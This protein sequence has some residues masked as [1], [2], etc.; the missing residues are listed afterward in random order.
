MLNG[1]VHGDV[2]GTEESLQLFLNLAYDLVDRRDIDFLTTSKVNSK[3]K[4]RVDTELNCQKLLLFSLQKLS[5]F[6]DCFKEVADNR[7]YFL[8][9]LKRIG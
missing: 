3:E 9:V 6:L 7:Q 5:P 8:D 2:G 1:L 4:S